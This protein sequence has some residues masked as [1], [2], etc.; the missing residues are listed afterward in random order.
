MIEKGIIFSLFV[1]ALYFIFN[2]LK[3]EWTHSSG[4][5]SCG[6]CSKCGLIDKFENLDKI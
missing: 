1:F 5:S 2:K 4:C 6:S 3:K